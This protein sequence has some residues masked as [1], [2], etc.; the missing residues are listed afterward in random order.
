MSRSATTASDKVYVP[1]GI[2]AGRVIE[3]LTAA[4]SPSGRSL[5]S[6]KNPSVNSS[7]EP[8]SQRLTAMVEANI[9][10]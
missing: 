5:G 1:A 4:I 9:L 2:S 8:G 3:S 6:L 10:L 7:I